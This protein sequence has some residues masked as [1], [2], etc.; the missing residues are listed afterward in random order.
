MVTA[1][2]AGRSG[3]GHRSVDEFIANLLPGEFVPHEGVPYQKLARQLNELGYTSVTGH[4][5]SNQAELTQALQNGPVIITAGGTVAGARAS[6]SLVVTAIS[7]SGAWV[8]LN[9]PADGLSHTISWAKFDNLWAGGSRGILL[10][11]P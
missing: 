11:K 4:I 1:F 7:T 10:I 3:A 9:D 2:Y 8:K 5:N 6:H